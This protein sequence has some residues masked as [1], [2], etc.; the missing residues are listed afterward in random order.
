MCTEIPGP[1][2]PLVLLCRQGKLQAMLPIQVPL[3]IR[4]L[5]G[6][7]SF[8]G[9]LVRFLVGHVRLYSVMI[10]AVN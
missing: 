7:C 3:Y 5:H 8:L 6:L 1:V 9:A 10:R 4:L 2:R